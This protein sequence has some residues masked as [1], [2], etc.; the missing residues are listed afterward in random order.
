MRLVAKRMRLKAEEMEESM[1]DVR[2]EDKTIKMF[3]IPTQE[4]LS[5]EI[6]KITSYTTLKDHKPKVHKKTVI[7]KKNQHLLLV[8]PNGIGK[9]TLLKSIAEMSSQGIEIGKGVVVGYY[10]QDFSNLNFEAT[11]YE[12]LASA[13]E[14]EIEERLRATAAGFLITGEMIHTKIGHLSVR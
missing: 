12:E 1:V 8:G 4:N 6:L 14:K 10:R 7:L 13:M 3:V 2:R 9:S 5:G 11:V